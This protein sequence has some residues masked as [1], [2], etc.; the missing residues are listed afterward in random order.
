MVLQKE[1]IISTYTGPS[2]L[3]VIGLVVNSLEDPAA[4]LWIQL[5]DLQDCMLQTQML[6]L[7][8]FPAEAIA[9]VAQH[10]VLLSVEAK[11]P[12]AA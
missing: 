10:Q 2:R 1:F 3:A 7:H 6:Q 9:S 8:L 5:Q 12:A 11:A 4:P